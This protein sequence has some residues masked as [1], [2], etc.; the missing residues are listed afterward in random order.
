MKCH[1]GMEL[2]GMSDGRVSRETVATPFLGQIGVEGII[3]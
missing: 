1:V 2:G 3:V